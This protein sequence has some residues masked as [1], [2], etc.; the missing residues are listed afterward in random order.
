M[1]AVRPFFVALVVVGIA[2]ACDRSPTAPLTHSPRA[3]FNS[4]SNP[5]STGLVACSQGYDSVTQVIGPRGGQIAVGAHILFVD[6]LVL[7][8]SVTITAVAPASTVRWVRFQP[9]GLVFPTNAGDGWGAILYTS[10]K[11][12]SLS[13]LASPRIAQVSDALSVLTYLQTYF[14]IKQVP[15]SQGNQYV[16]GLLPHFSNYAVAW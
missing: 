16:V 7:A 13:T 6:S 9:D 11:D 3:Q 1:S 12:C 5:K 14:K 4:T 2:V 10:Y 8:T 15:W